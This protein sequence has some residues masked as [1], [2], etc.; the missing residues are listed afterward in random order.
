MTIKKML[1]YFVCTSY[2]GIAKRN[3]TK[4]VQIKTTLHK[5]RETFKRRHL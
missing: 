4:M 5:I 1:K 2:L 3:R